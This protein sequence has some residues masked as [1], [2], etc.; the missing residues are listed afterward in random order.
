MSQEGI[1]T[2]IGFSSQMLWSHT[3][4]VFLIAWGAHSTFFSKV[5]LDVKS[6]IHQDFWKVPTSNPVPNIMVIVRDQCSVT[7][8]HVWWQR[9]EI[10][11]FFSPGWWT[12]LKANA[13]K[14]SKFVLQ[15]VILWEYMHKVSALE[16]KDTTLI[17]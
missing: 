14:C 10:K 3:I 2:K 13:E 12:Y 9:H 15:K 16:T 6:F 11:L 4:R 17:L 7:F 8:R 5:N 1:W